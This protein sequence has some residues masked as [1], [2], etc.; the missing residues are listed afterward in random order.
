MSPKRM[1]R[2]NEMLDLIGT[3]RL[4]ER[5]V[6]AATIEDRMFRLAKARHRLRQM[7][8][9]LGGNEDQ[10]E[11]TTEAVAARKEAVIRIDLE[12][13]KAVLLHG[14]CDFTP[15]DAR[16]ESAR[17]P[18]WI[19]G[20]MSSEEVEEFHFRLSEMHDVDC[21]WIFFDEPCNHYRSDPAKE[22]IGQEE[23][24]EWMI[25]VGIRKATP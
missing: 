7:W 9:K 4:G 20:N 8:E 15:T 6:M 10:D 25:E 13:P 19:R 11:T 5:K 3:L 21:G 1:K 16:E 23:V 17:I 18:R 22:Q 14:E 24:L 12:I 2:E